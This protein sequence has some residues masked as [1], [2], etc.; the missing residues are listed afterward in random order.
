MFIRC[1][2]KCPVA[3]WQGGGQGAMALPQPDFFEGAPNFFPGRYCK[4]L[5][6]KPN[7]KCVAIG[8]KQC[9]SCKSI[10]KSQCGK[11]AC[12]SSDGTKPLMV[13]IADSTSIKN[14][15]NICVLPDH[16]SNENVFYD[17]YEADV[18]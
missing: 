13:R 16:S 8:L 11:K 1:K 12:R 3:T 18:F 17:D 10:L 14:C 4:C 2:D 7:E 5:C 9:S 15:N 6:E